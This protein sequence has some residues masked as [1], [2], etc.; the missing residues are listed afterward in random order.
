MVD[1]YEEIGRSLADPA[2]IGRQRDFRDLSVEYARLTPVAQKFTAFQALERELGSAR[3]MQNDGDPAMR[4]MGAE[5]VAR[6]APQIASCRRIAQGAVDPARP[7]RRQEHLSR[8]AR[9]HRRR[10]SR[11]LRGRPVPHVRAFCGNARLQ[12]RNPVGK[13]RRARRLPRSHQPHRGQQ[14]VRALQ[15]R[16]RRAS[17]ATRAGDGGAG[18]HP[19]LR[20]H[21]CHPG[22]AR[23]SGSHRSQ[24]RGAARR[25]VPRVGRRRPARQQDRIG[26]PHHAHSHRGSSSN[27]RTSARSTRTARARWRS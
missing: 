24:S 21:R 9:R 27:A 20:G 25:H 14:R 2:V 11:H 12:R 13:S 18:A 1:R 4:E 10:R 22:R 7:A 15:V 17:R 16:I 6:L 8:S 26:H 5:E 23:R 19:H 3:D